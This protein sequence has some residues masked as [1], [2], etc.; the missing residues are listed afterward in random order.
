MIS[1]NQV[2]QRLTQVSSLKAREHK[3]ID[4]NTHRSKQLSVDYQAKSRISV[5]S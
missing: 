3:I 5:F 4:H 1:E 2:F